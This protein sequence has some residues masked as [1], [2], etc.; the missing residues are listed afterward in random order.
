MKKI[1]FR[2]KKTRII[3]GDL[4]K[5]SKK[6]VPVRLYLTISQCHVELLPQQLQV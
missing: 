1:M 5:K 6:Y 2:R 3:L 4:I